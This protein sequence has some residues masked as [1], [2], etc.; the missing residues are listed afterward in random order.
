MYII[1]ANLIQYRKKNIVLLYKIVS[2]HQ[3]LLTSHTCKLLFSVYHWF[4]FFSNIVCLVSCYKLDVT[5][6]ASFE[7]TAFRTVNFLVSVRWQGAVLAS[8][9]ISFSHRFW[10]HAYRFI[11]HQC[12]WNRWIYLFFITQYVRKTRFYL[13][14]WKT[15]DY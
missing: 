15:L 8:W 4:N 12:N 5:V 14:D 2:R 3:V 7:F 1:D 10:M 13:Q 11:K 9:F 6:F